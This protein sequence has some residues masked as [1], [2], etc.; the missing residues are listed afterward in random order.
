MIR[1]D[2]LCTEVSTLT[3]DLKKQEFMKLDPTPVGTSAQA[4]VIPLH[5]QSRPLDSTH[6]GTSQRPPS[7]NLND[8]PPHIPQ[9]GWDSNNA[10]DGALA[11]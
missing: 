5:R 6:A 9:P 4:A 11:D 2:K 1:H 10:M 8:F 3:F 7:A